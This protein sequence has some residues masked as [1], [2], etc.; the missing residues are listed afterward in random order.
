MRRRRIASLRPHLLLACAAFA[1]MAA[2]TQPTR[3][4]TLPQ[5]LTKSDIRL[6]N[7][8][9]EVIEGAFP[10]LLLVPRV[11]PSYHDEKYQRP[12]RYACHVYAAAPGHGAEPVYRRRFLVCAPGDD[13]APFVRQVARLLLLLYGE[14]RSHLRDDHPENLATV[15]VWLTEGV[16]AGLSPDTGGEQFQNQIYLYNLHRERTPIE[17]A[18]E[19]AHEYGH[20]AI[21]GIA[22]FLQPEE[23]ANGVLGERLFLKWI[24]EDVKSGQ[25]RGDSLPFI[26]EPLL[27]E[28]FART[29]WPL[30]RRIMA[31]GTDGQKITNR[32]ATGMDYYTGIVMYVDTLYGTPTLV[33]AILDTKSASSLTFPRSSDF[34]TGLLTALKS[35]SEISLKLPALGDAEKENTV[36]FYLPAGTWSVTPESSL[37]SWRIPADPVAG[38]A[39]TLRQVT[40]RRGGW[41]AVTYVRQRDS[42]MAARLTFRKRG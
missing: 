25:L 9:S 19:I 6:T 39:C 10:G 34:L 3:A 27:D 32:V 35:S 14:R 7:A 41:Y 40:V 28:F 42:T 20:Y 16:E 8:D 18:R 38:V 15:N 31:Q 11:R 13:A 23:W 2:A 24:R 29:I 33:D 36:H 30:V 4:Q 37:I 22:G 1:I 17:W 5:E 12:Y 21:P 26:D